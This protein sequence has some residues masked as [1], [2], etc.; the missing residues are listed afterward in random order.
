MSVSLRDKLRA[1][2]SKPKTAAPAPREEPVFRECWHGMKTTPLSELP[3]AYELRRDTLELMQSETLPTDF[4]PE[5]ILYLDTETTGLSGGAG[6]VAFL[7]GVGFLTQDGFQV[8]QYVMRDYPEERYLLESIA[9]VADQFDMLCTFNGRTFDVP[10]LRSR[11][12]MNRMN[13]SVLDKPHIDLLPMARRLWKLR[14]GRCNLSRL[15]E[16]VFGEPRLDDL[17][18]SEVPERYF[19][20]IKTRDFSLLVDVLEHNR[21]DVASLCRLLTH[22]TDMYQAPEN[23]GHE[24]DVYSMG[25][26]LEKLKHVEQARRCYR[27]ASHG[28]TQTLSHGRLAR[29]YRRTGDL[30]AAKAGWLEMIRLH[31]GWAEPYVE[32]AK[33]YEH[34]DKDVTAALEMTRAALALVSEPCLKPI[35]TV[36]ETK[37][38]L[39]YRYARLCR[40]AHIVGGA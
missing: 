13:P 39:Q 15:E 9:A 10:L 34:R 21:Q 3:S 35:Q 25:V 12:L 32:L 30:D 40:K 22:M 4:S 38:A 17:P 26:N 20:Y 23:Q 37:N 24:Q 18:G 33:L 2:E 31:E 29:S 7:T 19:S 36:Q 8:H 16:V 14:L 5:K 6:T 1:I 28:V 27:L 11:F